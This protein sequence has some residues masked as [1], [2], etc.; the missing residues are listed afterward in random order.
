MR[1]LFY[2]QSFYS[3]TKSV[4]S[5]EKL[6]QKAV[7]NNY[8]FVT[9]SDDENLYGMVEFISVCEKNR[10]KPVVGLRIFVSLERLFKGQ[11]IG[12]L[13]YASNDI[14]L[15]HLIQISNL[16]R[17]RDK[18]IT[19]EE[20]SHLQEGL[21]FIL[22]NIDFLLADLS[23]P[24]KMQPILAAFKTHLKLFYVGFSLQNIRLA[25]MDE[26]F[27]SLVEKLELT[28]L[29]VHKTN[30][31]GQEDRENYELLLKLSHPESDAK[32]NISDLDA[33]SFHFLDKK[34]FSA[35][36]GPYFNKYKSF[37]VDLDTLIKPIRYDKL[38]SQELHL[39]LFNN[40]KGQTSFQYLREKTFMSLNAKL[41][42]Q[43]IDTK[44]HSV[45][46]YQKQL[47]K[48][49]KIIVDLR[50]EDYFLIVADFLEYAR[51]KD[52]LV[53]PGRGSSSGSLVCFCL[54]ITEADPLKY[55]LLFERFLNYKRK[56]LPDI[57]LDFPDEK[58][59][60]V[61]QYIAD[62]YGSEHIANIIT[63]NTFTVKSLIRDLIR[64]KEMNPF[65]NQYLD[66]NKEKVLLKME[67]IPKLT[68]IHPAGIILSKDK[69]FDFYPLQK[70]YQTNSPIKYQMQL[71]S[72]QLAKIG[73]LKIDLLS[74]K[75]LSL[76]DK[77]LKQINQKEKL[78]WHDIPLDKKEV[79]HTLQT[80]NTDY[81]F[82]LESFS[83]KMV[84]KKIK[85]QTFEELVAVLSFNRPGPLSFLDLYCA[86]RKNNQTRFIHPDVD[87][88]LQNTYGVI[89]FQEQVMEIS[90][91]FAGYDLGQA[92]ILM[93]K[94]I[95]NKNASLHNDT[96]KKDFIKNSVQNKKHSSALSAQVYDY[97]VKFSNYSFNKSHSVAYSLIS[98]RMSYLKTY[99]LTSFYIVMLNEYIK[100]APET[101]KLLK[102]SQDKIVFIKP[103]ILVS[104]SHYQNINQQIVMPLTII[105][106][107]SEEISRFIVQE[108]KKQSFKDFFDFK[109]RLKKVLNDELLKNLIFSGVLDV[110]G[111]NRKTLMKRAKFELLAHEIYLPGFSKKTDAEYTPGELKKET[112]KVF[113]FDVDAIIERTP[114]KKKIL[115]N[116]NGM[117]K[118]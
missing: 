94:M 36:Y 109:V 101:A 96:L 93:R 43:Q 18:T 12:L 70:N 14:G 33:F 62:K 2:L 42:N 115:N 108:R 102:E 60:L 21:F 95:Q 68:G 86:N 47:E 73:L 48:E 106:G 92:E 37:C 104:E 112:I 71:E 107:I 74:L 10:I 39:P 9:L 66:K 11:K 65:F 113:G 52:I 111:L 38:F 116:G 13:V 51:K 5:I 61:T 17:T 69:L 44:L 59:H 105:Y 8:D 45:A 46:Q 6:V 67:G 84:L 35:Q 87:R 117:E 24:N 57:D 85:P 76:V 29:P 75:S 7:Q 114:Q 89:L 88:V 110:F 98:Y 53:G 78:L 49:L 41:K 83:A 81:I 90:V 32:N 58:I 97:I 30:Y 15:R 16:I 27:F 82:Q 54:G 79:Y 103:N 23:A 1:G 55:N 72:K 25:A 56:T 50:Y 100:N 19:L 4:N 80:G 40:N 26:H 63:F 91:R 77:I 34:E 64:L 20:I 118:I 28:A 22:S 31:L 99:H 3:I